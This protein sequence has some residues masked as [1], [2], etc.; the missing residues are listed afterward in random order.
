[1]DLFCICKPLAGY[2]FME[3]TI[4]NNNIN[5]NNNNNNNTEQP[6][7]T[8][9]YKLRSTPVLLSEIEKYKQ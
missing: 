2:G 5:N 4:N 3:S 8:K 6:K 1:M 7:V 9:K